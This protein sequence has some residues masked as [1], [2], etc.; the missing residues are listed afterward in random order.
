MLD[1]F[2]QKYTEKAKV[3]LDADS[4]DPQVSF[5][6]RLYCYR[7]VGMTK[8]WLLND[9]ITSGETIVE[10]MNSSMPESMRTLFYK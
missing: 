9:N 6:I 7:C 2:E 3:L 5:T 4:L 1:Y 10:M 8:E